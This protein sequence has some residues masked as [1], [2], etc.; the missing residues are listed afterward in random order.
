MTFCTTHAA[1]GLEWSLVYVVGME[2][3]TFPIERADTDAAEELRLFYVAV[4]RARSELVLSHATVA[5]RGPKTIT[6]APSAFLE[7]VPD[8]RKSA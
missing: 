3:G 4:T 2:R 8:V 1:K 7:L 5:E 6:V